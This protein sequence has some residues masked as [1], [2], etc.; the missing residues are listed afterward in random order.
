MHASRRT[1]LKQL[2]SGLAAISWAPSAVLFAESKATFTALPRSTP[3]AQC[4]SSASIQAFFDALATSN[5]EMHGIVMVR[6]GHVIAEGWWDPYAPDLRHTLYS[7]SKSFTS[8][9]VGF[10]VAEGR[11]KV[12]DKVVSFSPM[13]CPPP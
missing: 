2:G 6:R 10:A 3:E 9:A 13:T 4:V 11:L 12:T 7:M 5:H 1:F 8:T